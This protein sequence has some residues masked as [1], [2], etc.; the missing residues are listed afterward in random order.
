MM[1]HVA[2]FSGI[3]DITSAVGAQTITVKSNDGARCVG[4]Y[5]KL[6]TTAYVVISTVAESNDKRCS[7][8]HMIHEISKTL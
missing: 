8:G 2:G 5:H 4:I 6:E 7:I 1:T 3:V